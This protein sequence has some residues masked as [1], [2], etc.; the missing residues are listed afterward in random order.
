MQLVNETST[1]SAVTNQP[2]FTTN[3]STSS[4][5]IPNQDGMTSI[6]SVDNKVSESTVTP[7]PLGY[8]VGVAVGGL[9]LVFVV[10]AVIVITLLVV[11][12]GQAHKI[13]EGEEI[14]AS[15]LDH[16]NEG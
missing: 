1:I 5:V 3:K 15:S 9:L 2:M 8:A 12:R 11:K 7:L 10:V 14:L 16:N 4:T 6:G 13:P